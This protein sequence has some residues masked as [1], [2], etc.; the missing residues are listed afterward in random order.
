MGK[1][2]L[3]LLKLQREREKIRISQEKIN[4]VLAEQKQ[5][6]RK[7]ETRRKVL[8][9]VILQEMIV[10]GQIPEQLFNEF[11][12]KSLNERDRSVFDGYL[13]EFLPKQS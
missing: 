4:R 7:F 11:L 10:E 1:E 6:R 13:D 8:L 9:G 3:H 2:D 12:E 5:E